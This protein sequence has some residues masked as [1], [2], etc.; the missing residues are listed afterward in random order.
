[1][2]A[3]PTAQEMLVSKTQSLAEFRAR[4]TERY[5]GLLQAQPST[6]GPPT[7]APW[8]VRS[9]GGPCAGFGPVFLGMCLCKILFGFGRCMLM[10]IIVLQGL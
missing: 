8:N 9:H 6:G 3:T 10:V 4:L 5:K 7:V 1:M 2:G